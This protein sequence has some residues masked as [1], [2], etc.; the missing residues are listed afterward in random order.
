[1]GYALFA[2]RKRVLDAE[3]N[4]AQLQQTIKANAQY[5]LATQE[6]SLNQQLTSQSAAQSL[7]LASLYDDLANSDDETERNQINARIS[8]KEKEF[9][10]EAD[11]INREIYKIS[12]Q[13]SAIELEV[14]R[15]DTMVTALQQQLDAVEQAEGPA[16]QRATPHFKGLG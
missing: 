3:L 12:S 6:L 13:E 5:A 9:D 15:L 2:M 14:K 16:I 4:Q 11:N 8:A 7:E 10:A 1:M